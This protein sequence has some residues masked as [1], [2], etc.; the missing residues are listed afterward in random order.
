MGVV[1]RCVTDRFE[2]RVCALAHREAGVSGWATGRWAW[3]TADLVGAP[4]LGTRD[5]PLRY[6][7]LRVLDGPTIRGSY[8]PGVGIEPTTC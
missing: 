6:P 8:E 7:S 3:P 1:G 4:R 2:C 5:D